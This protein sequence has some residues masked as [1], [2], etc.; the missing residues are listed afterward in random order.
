MT[1]EISKSARKREATRLQDVGRALTQLKAQ[2][3]QTFDLP[4]SLSAA[5][6]EYKRINSREGGRRQRHCASHQRW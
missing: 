6:K 4:A 2:D 1:E 5:I 3:L